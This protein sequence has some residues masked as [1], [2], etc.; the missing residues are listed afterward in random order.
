MRGEEMGKFWNARAE[1]DAFYFVDNRLKFGDG[2]A[3]RFWADGQVVVDG[4][5]GELGVA[6]AP[7]DRVVEIGCG[8]G[9][10]TRVLSARAAHVRAL[11][12]S[13]RML[14]LAAEHN[15]ELPNV[16]WVLGDGF[17]LD[18]LDD[19]SADAF[20]SFVVFQHIPD[21]GVTLN[22]VREMGRVLGPGGWSAFQISNA[23]DVHRRTSLS[24]RLLARARARFGTG[25]TGQDHAA[26]RGSSVELSDLR[27]VAA[28]AGMS[29]ER[30][31]GEGTQF[32]LVLLRRHGGA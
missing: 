27:S 19:G 3:E 30:T 23:P 15:P 32:C 13:E 10:L 24:R 20:L 22:Y 8:V 1:E 4:M 18:G 7:G 25:P 21:P 31:A 14:A 6:V 28:E 29:V 16:E 5:L 17:S 2:D 26:W 11:D 12:V 9:R